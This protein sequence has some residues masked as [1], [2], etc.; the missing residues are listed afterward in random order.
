L[1]GDLF[2]LL[3]ALTFVVE[4]DGEQVN[5]RQLDVFG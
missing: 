1:V 2:D 3:V 5:R 4:L